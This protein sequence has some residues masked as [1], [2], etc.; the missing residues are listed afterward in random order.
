MAGRLDQSAANHPPAQPVATTVS[1]HPVQRA[2]YRGGGYPGREGPL[3]ISATDAR[4]HLEVLGPSG[5]G[6]S[7]LLGR[8]IAQ[9]MAA[10]RGV[11]VVE[12]KSDLINYCLTQV[13]KERLDDVVLIAPDRKTDA[14]VGFNP[15]AGDRRNPEAAA[16]QL[17]AV[18]RG[19]YGT[20]F[21]PRTTDIA[22]AALHTLARVPGMTLAALPLLLTDAS[23]RRRIVGQVD[24]PVSLSPFWEQFEQWS[25]TMQAV[26][27][28]PL[29]SR[30]RPFLLRPQLRAV[31]GQPEPRFDVRDVFRR[32]RILLVDCSVGHLGP[33]VAALLGS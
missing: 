26:A 9:D 33:E 17:L 14:V 6:K 24:D 10:G 7:V 13:P 3:A 5:V 12:P 28:A 31:L 1:A 23:F 2:D 25:P 32:R 20:T 11:V 8:L 18:F 19:L 22:G 4:R 30:V 15:L 16:D 29:L 27:T 21:G